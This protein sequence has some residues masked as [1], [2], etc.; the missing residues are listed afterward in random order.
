MRLGWMLF[1]TVALIISTMFIVH[2]QGRISTADAVFWA[3]VAACIVL[4][5]V[6]IAYM[7]GMTVSGEPATAAHWRRYTVWMLVG[8]AAVWGA[9]HGAGR[10]W[11]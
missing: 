9:A 6:D 1:G 7:N 4:R 10:L 8:S 11:G 5:Y 2:A 3:V